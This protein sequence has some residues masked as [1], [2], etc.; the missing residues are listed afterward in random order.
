MTPLDRL[1]TAIRARASVP[2]SLSPPAA[3]LW[4]DARREW[5]SLLPAARLHIPEL[6]VL[7][8]Y[9]PDDRTGP[10]IWLR[11]VVDRTV[12]LP[13][14][15]AAR[16]PIIYMPGVEREQLRAGEACPGALRPLVELMYR[17]LCWHHLNGRDWSVR[18]F[19][20][21]RADGRPAGP[22]LNIASDSETG[23]ALLRAIGEVAQTPVEELRGRRLDANDFNRLLGVDAV[24]DILRW[25]GSP[26]ATRDQMDETRWE[27]FCDEARRELSFDPATGADV[28]A[29]T[30]LAAG[31]GRWEDAWVRF[32]E[33]PQQFPGVAEVLGRSRP[34]G[35][36]ILN[37]RDRW[38][39]LN[40]EDEKAVRDALEALPSL[41]QRD[42][43]RRIRQLEAD[44]GHR[45]EWVWAAMGRSPL[46]RALSPLARVA[47]AA[48][49][50]IGGALPDDIARVY[51]QR[52]WQADRGAREAL[53]IATPEHEQVVA[54]AVRHLLKPWLDESARTFQAAVWNHPLRSADAED[55]EVASPTSPV[56]AREKECLLF[57]DGLR[58][59]LGLCLRDRLEVEG[60]SARMHC[61]WAAIPTV[62]AT[63]KPAVT[64]VAGDIAGDDI[65]AEFLPVLR[66][67]RRP[68]RAP[69]L[70]DAIRERGYEIVGDGVL[71][72][73]PAVHARAWGETGAIDRHGHHHGATGFARQVK[74]EL[75]RLV[76]RVNGLLDAG[77]HFV[78]IV[79]DH[80]WLLLPGG[81]PKVTLPRH[82]TESQWARCAV[83]AGDSSPDAPLH[84]W[85]WNESEH[86][87]SPPGIACFS[88]RPEYAH[89]G[90]SIQEC[91]I[92]D[93]RVSKPTG[94]GGAAAPT[95]VVRSVDWVRMRCNIRV[96]VPRGDATADLRLGSPSGESVASSPK[97]IDADG[98]ASLIVP[99]DAHESA[100]LVLVVTA[101]DGRILAQRATR[102][103]ET[104]A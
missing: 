4:T 44:H 95:A 40:E 89:G 98:C 19:L 61:R 38:P 74:G 59:E 1:A 39:D 52:G 77:W 49:K 45:R 66:D 23:A 102:K 14:L 11:C 30:K 28:E 18:A 53:A 79:T 86:F 97:V 63:A 62:T 72:L 10:A 103:G 101:A 13:N 35:A 31:S 43:C 60:L 71:E 2:G 41:P 83:P 54:K 80:G 32:T 33:A 51:A 34:A 81:L 20:M 6:L 15:P 68:A 90:L 100:A 16:P 46:A 48:E 56:T 36:L 21:L 85:H 22:G 25:I 94:P 76:H 84:P 12:E 29:G 96:D 75:D 70:R 42:A 7:G 82:L 3:I 5:S 27:A 64:P 91:L 26:K 9:S 57:V 104:S 69:A 99:D 78:R 93:I 87:A 88:S 8:D 17:G 50:S 47:A 92:P 73:G 67:S 65:G 58:Y 37:R 24:R 55:S